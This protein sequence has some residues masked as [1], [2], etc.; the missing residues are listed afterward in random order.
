M[1]KVKKYAFKIKQLYV[2]LLEK[3]EEEEISFK[4]FPGIITSI[5]ILEEKCQKLLNDTLKLDPNHA[6]VLRAYAQFEGMHIFI[7]F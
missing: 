5:Q 4:N 7:K 1:S 6:G 3:C 2:Q